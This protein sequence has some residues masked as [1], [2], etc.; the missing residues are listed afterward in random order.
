MRTDRHDEANRRVTIT[1]TRL[2]RVAAYHLFE[3][4]V[5][6]HEYL[7]LKTFI[8]RTPLCPSSGGHDDSEG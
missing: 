5:C 3:G 6:I 1:R 2:K 4:P 7:K 8:F